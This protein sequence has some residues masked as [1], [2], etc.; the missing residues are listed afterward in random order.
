MYD[1]LYLI[2]DDSSL[3]SV[4]LLSE[5]HQPDRD[6]LNYQRNSNKTEKNTSTFFNSSLLLTLTAESLFTKVPVKIL[7]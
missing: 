5:L 7:L 1:A 3:T 6:I 4:V 2:S